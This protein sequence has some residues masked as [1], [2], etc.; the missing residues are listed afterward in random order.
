MSQENPPSVVTVTPGEASKLTGI[1][2]ATLRVLCEDQA[3]PGAVRGERGSYR[4]RTDMLPTIEQ[5]ETIL[6]ERLDRAVPQT[7]AA[8][9]RVKVELEA[10]SNDIAQ[11]EDDPAG[12][13]GIDLAAFDSYTNSTHSTL[14]QALARLTEAKTR[15]EQDSHM[16]QQIIPPTAHR[17]SE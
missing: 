17:S 4:L 9:D 6:R 7:R 5:V 3:L 8:F 11:L 15:L 13:I 2:A 12:P 1:S 16:L 10:V 14:R